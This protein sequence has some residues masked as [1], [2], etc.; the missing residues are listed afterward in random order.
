MATLPRGPMIA[1][2][3]LIRQM[4]L[5]CHHWPTPDPADPLA[6]AGGVH[7]DALPPPAD[8]TT[9]TA[10]E[11]SALRPFVLMHQAPGDG[12]RVRVRTAAGDCLTPAGH[13]QIVVELPIPESIESDHAMGLHVLEFVGR[14]LYTG[15]AAEPGIMDLSGQPGRPFIRAL[16]VGDY[17]RIP[18][19]HVAEVGDYVACDI[20]LYWGNDA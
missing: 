14:L 20:D 18:A 9:Y 17:G 10:D 16:T 11:L 13:V 12:F 19:E 15:D 2:V 4:L 8:G 1:A 7:I 3:E 5:D 6:I